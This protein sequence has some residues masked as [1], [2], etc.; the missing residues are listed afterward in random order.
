MEDLV[1]TTAQQ[2]VHKHQA[3]DLTAAI[4]VVVAAA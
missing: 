2:Q 1:E 3:Q 4:M